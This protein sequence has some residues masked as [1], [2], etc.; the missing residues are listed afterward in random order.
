MLQFR[1]IETFFLSPLGKGQKHH[2]SRQLLAP[3]D[4]PPGLKGHHEENRQN[5]RCTGFSII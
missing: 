1:K 3:T 5:P 2:R 4:R